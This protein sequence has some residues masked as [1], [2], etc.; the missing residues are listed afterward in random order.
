MSGTHDDVIKW[1][2][3]PSYWPFVRGIHRSPVNSPHKGQW[4]GALIFSL[5][6]SWINSWVN[7]GETGDFRRHRA[8]YDV[9]VM[10]RLLPTISDKPVHDLRKKNSLKSSPTQNDDTLLDLF[11]QGSKWPTRGALWGPVRWWM[12]QCC[13][14]GF[15]TQ[16]CY[17]YVCGIPLWNDIIMQCKYLYRRNKNRTSNFSMNSLMPSDAYMR[18]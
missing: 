2:H 15:S 16:S 18:Q 11:S 4:R 14:L 7:N 5:I 1:K 6:C 8:H 10:I 13:G 12:Y 9:I 17:L 3:F